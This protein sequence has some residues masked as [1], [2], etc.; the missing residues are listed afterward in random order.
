MI[1]EHF[2]FWL[3]TKI[4]LLQSTLPQDD[5]R[6]P[7]IAQHDYCEGQW[8][9]SV[10]KLAPLKLILLKSKL[11]NL[12]KTSL[13]CFTWAPK[14]VSC[15][16]DPGPCR[17]QNFHKSGNIQFNNTQKAFYILWFQKIFNWSMVQ[18]DILCSPFWSDRY[19]MLAQR[20]SKT[21]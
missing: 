15:W 21:L 19:L 4:G 1:G 5:P 11:D 20:S 12:P 3:F 7:K 14:T 13:F 9:P 18:L 10:S 8:N 16:F 17:L 6:W 2:R